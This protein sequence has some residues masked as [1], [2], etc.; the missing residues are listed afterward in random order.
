MTV[1]L[2]NVRVQFHTSP[3]RVTFLQG[4][5]M[6]V[7]SVRDTLRAI[8]ETDEGR[9]APFYSGRGGCICVA[10]G[11]EDFSEVQDGS[12]LNALTV[13]ILSPFI[14]DFEAG[15]LPFSTSRGNLLFTGQDSPGAI[16]KINNAVG[17]IMLNSAD[18]EFS[19]FNNC[20]TIDPDHGYA[21]TGKLPDGRLIGTLR[22]PSNNLTDAMLILRARGLSTVAAVGNLT[23]NSGGDYTS[24]V[25]VGESMTKTVFTIQA[26]ANVE[27]AEFYSAHVMGT[28]DS[29]AEV[30]ECLIHDLNYVEGFVIDCILGAG[31][32]I[33]LGG[34]AD[35]VDCTCGGVTLATAPTIDCGG[36]GHDLV[37]RNYTGCLRIRN[38]TGPESITMD[39]NGTILIERATVTAGLVRVAGTGEIL[40]SITLE[41]ILESW[42]PNVTLAI[43]Q[44]ISPA[45]V[46]NA[47]WDEVGASHVAAGS[48]G[49]LVQAIVGGLTEQQATQLLELWRLKGLDPVAPLVVTATQRSIPGIVQKITQIGQVVTVKR[50]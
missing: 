38:K 42:N 29:N 15:P 7:P 31:G 24:V 36:S 35:F 10:S 47:V 43:D 8:E 4:A 50:Q 45:S 27:R 13:R 9:A 30:K 44:L 16:V 32:T 28:L 14:C 12:S 48:M 2:D 25:F 41:P 49:A 40:D 46:A 34:L 37:M 6:A 11:N 17:S 21:G 3:P 20:V 26:D 18:I 39:V 23:I 19:S 33:V 1:T 22:A 5:N